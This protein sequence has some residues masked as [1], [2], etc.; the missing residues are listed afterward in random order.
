[1]RIVDDDLKAWLE[2]RLQRVDD[3]SEIRFLADLD[4]LRTLE[5]TVANLVAG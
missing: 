2:A 5:E 4:R 1:M 3:G